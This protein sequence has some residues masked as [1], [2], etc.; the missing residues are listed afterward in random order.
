MRNILI[1]LVINLLIFAS[2]FSAWRD[3]LFIASVLLLLG[4]IG[5]YVYKVI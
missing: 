1:L 4:F 2:I 5:M 3:K